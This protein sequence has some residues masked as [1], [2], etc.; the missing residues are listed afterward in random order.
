M[1]LQIYQGQNFKKSYFL[2][3]AHFS[4][5]LFPTSPNSSKA[6][7][8]LC[9]FLKGATNML[10]FTRGKMMMFKHSL[11][12]STLEII[13]NYI[14]KEKQGKIDGKRVSFTV[15]IIALI[16]CSRSFVSKLRKIFDENNG[17]ITL[18]KEGSLVVRDLMKIAKSKGD[19]FFTVGVNCS[20]CGFDK[21][22]SSTGSCV[23]CCKIRNQTIDC[24]S[25]IVAD[26]PEEVVYEIP[27]YSNK[28]L[29]E[30]G[31]LHL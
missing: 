12:R 18:Q 13:E 20:K 27:V 5:F 26:E 23:Y 19:K 9:F 8:G 31:L 11:D 17:S 15:E 28:T 1:L 4:S 30:T 21:R 3:R 16:N 25:D 10:Y 2:P 7:V 29:I 24:V 6:Q 14:A 22:Y